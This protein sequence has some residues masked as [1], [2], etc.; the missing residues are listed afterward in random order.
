LRAHGWIEVIFHP[1]LYRT[2]MCKSDYKNGVCREYGLYCAKS[3]SPNDIRNLVEIY[4][5]N[6]K[7]HYDLSAR[8]INVIASNLINF[9]GVFTEKSDAVKL[10][11]NTN[12]VIKLLKSKYNS[13]LLLG[14]NS[15]KRS[16][17]KTYSNY[18][19]DV[20]Y[21][22]SL[23]LLNALNLSDRKIDG[24]AK[25]YIELYGDDQIQGKSVNCFDNSFQSS[26]NMRGCLPI[27]QSPTPSRSQW[28]EPLLDFQDDWKNC[29]LY[30]LDTNWKISSSISDVCKENVDPKKRNPCF[31]RLVMTVDICEE[32]VFKI[33]WGSS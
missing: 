20:N 32:T 3:H 31:C 19:T 8:E 12:P 17:T 5:E 26:W 9:P 15:P 29:D 13:R 21:L 33:R 11:L 25:S 6:W 2:K 28:T 27:C 16:K 7:R 30:G 1:L 18:E 10:P 22:D 24:Q 4:G 14:R 23:P